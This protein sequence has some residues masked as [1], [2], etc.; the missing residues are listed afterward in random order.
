MI[1]IDPISAIINGINAI[2]AIRLG[3]IEEKALLEEVLEELKE[4]L[5]T[6]KDDYLKNGCDIATIITAIKINNLEK[7]ERARKRKKLDFNKIK[8]GKIH[9]SCFVSVHQNKYYSEFDTEKV[10]LKIREKVRK[11]KKVKSLY[12]KRNKWSSKINQTSRM[13]TVED[14]FVLLSNHLS[15]K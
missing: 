7:A 6:I 15:M 8:P 9:S 2:K 11:I 12:F 14:L 10:L 13:N 1:G 5:E 4:N 3:K